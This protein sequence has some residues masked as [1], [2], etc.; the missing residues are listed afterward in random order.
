VSRLERALR[1]GPD[2]EVVA[3][4]AEFES[5]GAPFSDVLDWTAVRGVVDRISLAEA[6]REAVTADPPDTAQ[7]ARLLPA[8]RAALGDHGLAGEPDWSALEQSVLRA[9][10]L[11]RLREALSDGDEARI[12]FAAVPDPYG[13]LNLLTPEEMERVESAL[14]RRPRHPD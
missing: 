12:A 4:L 6:L 14:Q 8:A 1:E 2:R 10:H 3:A 9:A 7:L 13:A 5:A 11:A